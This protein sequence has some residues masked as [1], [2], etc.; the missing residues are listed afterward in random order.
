MYFQLSLGHAPAS[1][2]SGQGISTAGLLCDIDT[3]REE[4]ARTD[5][6]TYNIEHFYKDR[7]NQVLCKLT[8]DA[9]QTCLRLISKCLF[10][11]RLF[12]P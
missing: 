11:S 8:H 2:V 4:H 9:D 3:V 6:A 7:L 12:L 10:L 5:D 1:S